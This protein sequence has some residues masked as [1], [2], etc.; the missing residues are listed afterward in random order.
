[1][2]NQ[3]RVRSRIVT[4]GIVCCLLA[5]GAGAQSGAPRPS[6]AN[7]RV[8]VAGTYTDLS[9]NREGGDILGTEIRIVGTRRGFQATVQVAEGSASPLIVGAVFAVDATGKFGFALP[10]ND[11]GLRRF[12]GV[13]V[14]AV[15]RGT[16]TFADGKTERVTLRRGRSYWD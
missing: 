1:M 6:A 5:A 4:A 8:R 10:S 7:A 11:L 12:D 15:L 13:I 3:L 16:F 2:Q 9:Y 14:G